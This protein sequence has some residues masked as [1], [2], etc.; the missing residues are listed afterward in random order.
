MLQNNPELK[1]KIDQLWNKFWSGGISNPL[2]AIEQITYLL[3]MKRLDELDQKRQG[4]AEWTG[5]KYTSKFEGTWIP[6]E[7]RNWPVAEQRPVDKRTL[8]WSEFKRMQAEEMLQHVQGKVFPFLKDLN[9]AESNF[10][11]HMKNAV[12]IIPKPA[13]LVEAVK[14]IDEIFEV[15]EKDSRENGQSFQ[16]IQGDVYEMLL[17]EIATAGKNGQFRTPRH[18]IKLMAELVQPQLGYKIADPAC[19]TGGFLLGA[20]QYIVTQLAIKAGTKNLEPDEDGFFRT[21]IAAALTE[22]VQA[23]LQESLYGY[24]IDATMVRLGLM[25]LM[26]HGIDEPHI[27]YQDTLSKSYNEEAEYDIVLAN[28]PFTGSIDKGDINENLQLSTTK[29]ELLFVENIYRLLKKGGTACV[30]VPQGVL[31]GS[32]GAFKTLRQMLVERCDLKAV[33]TLPSGVFKPYAGVSTAILLFTKVWGP[34]DKVSKAATEHVWFYEM[35][36]DG[37]S[38]DDKR[39]KQDGHGDLQDIIGRYYARD[40]ATDTDRTAKCFMVPRSEIADEKNNYDL[41][42]SRYKQDVFEEVHY[43]AP[44]VILDRLIQAEVGDVDEAELGKVKSG[45]VRELLELKGMVG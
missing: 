16:D 25:N 30:I 13:L 42:L 27:D 34:K 20:Y 15:M 17:A 21:S 4:D 11:H 36:A 23:I 41:S 8:R 28:P 29:T 44:V 9:G 18:I 39:S 38:L 3:F 22:K 24:D 5:E 40:A 35:A 33:I 10:T 43:D 31:F 7:E 26:M 1:S 12:F 6:P 14:T 2:T 19:G 32:G 37:Y 45:I